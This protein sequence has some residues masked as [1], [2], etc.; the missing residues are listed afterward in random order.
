MKVW[1]TDLSVGG[2]SAAYAENGLFDSVIL[3]LDK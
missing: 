1:V 2:L 3:S